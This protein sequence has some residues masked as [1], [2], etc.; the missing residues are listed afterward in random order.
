MWSAARI[1]PVIVMSQVDVGGSSAFLQSGPTVRGS[2]AENGYFI[3][4]MD[5]S[6]IEGNGAGTA[7][8]LD[9]FAFQEMNLQLGAAGNAARDRGGLV[10]NMITRTG[11]NQFHGGAQF[12]GSGR[13]PECGQFVGTAAD[14]A[15]WPRCR[16]SCSRRIRTS[17]RRRR[18]RTFPIPARGFPVR[19]FETGC[20][21]RSRQNT[22]C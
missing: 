5:I 8:F 16:R 12:A 4:G 7:F 18:S 1:S 19:S 20:G 13:Q 10:F 9:P 14:T 6:N 22:T 3:D 11:T 2:N 21:F 17:S 15:C